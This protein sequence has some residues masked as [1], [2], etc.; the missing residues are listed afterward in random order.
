MPCNHL[1]EDMRGGNDQNKAIPMIK[2]APLGGQ[3]LYA[4]FHAAFGNPKLFT[5]ILFGVVGFIMK[6]AHVKNEIKMP[7]DF[8]TLLLYVS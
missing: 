6:I 3:R 5:P 2:N 1:D 8:R 7:R 4:H